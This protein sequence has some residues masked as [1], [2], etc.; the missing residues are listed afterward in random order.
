LDENAKTRGARFPTLE[1]KDETIEGG[2][3]TRKVTVSRRDAAGVD[4]PI[5]DVFDFQYHSTLING[6]DKRPPIRQALSVVG[7]LLAAL[8]RVIASVRRP[9][10]TA[11]EKF[12]VAYGLVI[13]LGLVTYV[14]VLVATGAAAIVRPSPASSGG[15]SVAPQTPAVTAVVSPPARSGTLAVWRASASRTISTWRRFASEQLSFEK[16]KS[17]VVILSA[18]GLFSTVGIR[19]VLN[20]AATGAATASGYLATGDRVA[21]M[22][23]AFG[24]LLQHVLESEVDGQRYD[25]IHVVAFSFGSIVALDAL[26]PVVKPADHLRDIHSLV[27]IGCPFDF[28]RTYWPEYFEERQAISNVPSTWINVYAGA[29]V[30]GSNFA[31][32]PPRANGESALSAPAGKPRG[33]VLAAG[34]EER[35]PQ[36]LRYGPPG[37]L[38]DASILDQLRLIGFRLHARAYW[39]D[40]GS[41][42]CF[43]DVVPL[44]YDSHY[45]LT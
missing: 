16:L 40:I 32:S 43:H 39:E 22:R 9:A 35:I 42:S 1:G 10:K 37:D 27:T 12:Q 21:A 5:V 31:D 28:V 29:D 38:S 41:D 36:S 33:I 19:S 3:T 30:L 45:A 23:G 34:Q 18:I 14:V 17:L 20:T 24:R 13:A 11:A 6:F 25:R 15:D 26:F 4:V 8:G 2:H 7:T 44:L